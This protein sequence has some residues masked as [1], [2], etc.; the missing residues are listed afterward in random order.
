MY[1]MTSVCAWTASA[2]LVQVQLTIRLRQQLLDCGAD[3]RAKVGDGVEQRD[4]VVQG[5]GVRVLVIVQRLHKV[6][7]LT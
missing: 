5:Q 6:N 2:A 4:A 7:P 1:F 3:A